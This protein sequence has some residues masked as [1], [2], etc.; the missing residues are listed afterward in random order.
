MMSPY[1]ECHLGNVYVIHRK[2]PYL[3]Y[4]VVL[5]VNFTKRFEKSEAY[6]PFFISTIF[7]LTIIVDENA[8]QTD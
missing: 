3:I 8:F 1:L 4:L 7:K 6:H 5:K 2:M